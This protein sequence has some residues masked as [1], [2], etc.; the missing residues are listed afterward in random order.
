M[1]VDNLVGADVVLANGKMAGEF[2]GNS[3]LFWALRGSG[4]NFGVVTAFSRLHRTAHDRRRHGRPSYSP[5][6]TC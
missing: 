6:A 4:G 1:T 5:R 3:D 2:R